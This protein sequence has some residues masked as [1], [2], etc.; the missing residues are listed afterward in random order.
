MC[1][2]PD[3]KNRMPRHPVSMIWIVRLRL[4]GRPPVN[5][6]SHCQGNRRRTDEHPGKSGVPGFGRSGRIRAL[7]EIR[8]RG[9]FIIDD[10]QV[11]HRRGRGGLTRRRGGL[12]R[13]R[14]RLARRRS[15][16]TRRRSRHTRRR[17]R[18]TRRR[19]GLA[20]RRGG[21]TRRRGG[22]TRRRG[23]L[24]RRRGGHTRRRSRLARGR[25]GLA[26]GRGGL[27][28]RAEAEH[29]VAD[30][31][32]TADGQVPGI[33][34]PGDPVP[35]EA[36]ALIPERRFFKHTRSVIK[37]DIGVIR[38]IVLPK[39]GNYVLLDGL[40]QRLPAPDEHIGGLLD[41]DDPD[42]R[43]VEAEAA[44]RKLLGQILS[45]QDL[46]HIPFA[47]IRSPRRRE[48]TCKRNQAAQQE[49]TC[50]KARKEADDSFCHR[51]STLSTESKQ[52]CLT[53]YSLRP[54]GLKLVK[55]LEKLEIFEKI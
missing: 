9:F 51:N 45:V 43:Q 10:L 19:G 36:V 3:E 11:G 46:R 35:A 15:R 18:H 31:T 41:P 30:A 14:G 17:S 7:R 54:A 53:K 49:Q 33:S 40:V 27:A 22:P 26:C 1:P 12:T 20:R 21:P 24:A 4:L 52:F 39:C 2:F 28:R 13:R 44:I 47:V 5:Q 55:N 50:E 37:R 6:D 29:E 34:L 8:E 48:R 25:G 16:L 23:G 38:R 32:R 42:S